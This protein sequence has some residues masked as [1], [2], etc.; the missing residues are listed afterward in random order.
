MCIQVYTSPLKVGID[1]AHPLATRPGSQCRA[2]VPPVFRLGL[3]DTFVPAVSFQHVLQTGNALYRAVVQLECVR[4][5][6]V[7]ITEYPG[8]LFF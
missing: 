4:K 1:T 6:C 2:T 3:R 8:S 7:S 5:S